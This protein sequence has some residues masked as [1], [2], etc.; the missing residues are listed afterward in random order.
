MWAVETKFVKVMNYF[1]RVEEVVNTMRGLREEVQEAT[2]VQM[3]LRYISVRF[4]P[5]VSAIK[6]RENIDTIKLN[7][8]HGILIGYKLRKKSQVG[9][10][11]LFKLQKRGKIF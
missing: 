3:V 1:Q 9:R 11:P 4:N 2:T 8:V 6:D 10:K 5:K 7:E